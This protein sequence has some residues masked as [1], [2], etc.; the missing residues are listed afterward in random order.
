MAAFIINL[1]FLLRHLS[2]PKAFKINSFSVKHSSQEDD[3]ALLSTILTIFHLIDRI[4]LFSLND[5]TYFDNSVLFLLF[6][7]L[8]ELLWL[9]YNSLKVVSAN[10]R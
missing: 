4:L 7:L 5:E 6:S 3:V 1:V 2:S 8:N 9:V 10:P